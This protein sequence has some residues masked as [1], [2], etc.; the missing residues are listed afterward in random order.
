MRSQRIL[1]QVLRKHDYTRD[2]IH[3]YFRDKRLLSKIMSTISTKFLPFEPIAAAWEAAS[4]RFSMEDWIRT[5]LALILGNSETSRA[6][7]DAINRC[8]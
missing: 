1:K 4:G 7:I 3:L 6:A 8:I 2:I 5:E